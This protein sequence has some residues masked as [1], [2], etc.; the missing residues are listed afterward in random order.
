MINRKSNQTRVKPSVEAEEEFCCLQD[1]DHRSSSGSV[2]KGK[3]SMRRLDV[4]RNLDDVETSSV[5]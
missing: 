3:Q 5:L 1:G 2:T 4:K